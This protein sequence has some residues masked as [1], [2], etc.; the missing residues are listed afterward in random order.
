[1]NSN[2]HP[3]QLPARFPVHLT[4]DLIDDAL[5]GDLAAEHAAHL[6]TC[7]DCQIRLAEA[8]API[9]AFSALSLAW[10][11]RRSATLPTPVHSSAAAWLPRAIWGA[12]AAAVLVVGIS[13]PAVRRGLG[14]GSAAPRQENAALTQ[15]AS[16]GVVDNPLAAREEQIARDNR[17]LENIDRELDA[18]AP[19]PE[20]EYG[21][22]VSR[23][24]IDTSTPIRN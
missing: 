24:A 15:M 12:T 22:S 20:Q 8:G 19:S 13:V 1:M 7:D 21:V 23:T 10:S 3:N 18:S 14:V 4:E 17:M 6:A 11:E 5:I 2:L 16:T 9:A